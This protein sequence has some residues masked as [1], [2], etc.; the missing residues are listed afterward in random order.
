M[1]NENWL[2]PTGPQHEK[3]RE[4]W[5]GTGQEILQKQLGKTKLNENVAKNILIFIGDGMS[6]AT[7]MATRVYMGGEEKELSFEKFPYTGLTKTY[8]INYQGVY[9]SV[10]AFSVLVFFFDII[11]KG[12]KD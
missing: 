12:L 10:L 7:Q 4:Y 11:Y 9:L 6:L 1:D 3:S 8:C 5:Q 2:P